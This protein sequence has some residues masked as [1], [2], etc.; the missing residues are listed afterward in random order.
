MLRGIIVKK[1]LV[2]NVNPMDLNIL[3]QNFIKNVGSGKLEAALIFT[4][5]FST[6]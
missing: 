4:L 5:I 3:L 6:I 1:T 2:F